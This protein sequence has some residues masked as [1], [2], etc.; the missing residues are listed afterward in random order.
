MIIVSGQLF[1][2]GADN[3]FPKWQRKLQMSFS[4][5]IDQKLCGPILTGYST[6][7]EE[8][9]QCLMAAATCWELSVPRTDLAEIKSDSG[10]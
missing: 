2:V 7:V 3:Y 6:V 8:V 1:Y 10:C 5:L 9:L 4:G